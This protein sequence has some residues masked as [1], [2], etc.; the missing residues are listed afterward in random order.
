MAVN[1]VTLTTIPSKSGE[2]KTEIV[3]GVSQISKYLKGDNW[4]EKSEGEWVKF[5]PSRP[6]KHYLT[7]HFANGS[8]M[9]INLY[10]SNKEDTAYA[11]IFSGKGE[12]V[13]YSSLSNEDYTRVILSDELRD[14][15]LHNILK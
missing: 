11:S 10:F 2:E 5:Y 4:I 12:V 3:D 13:H 14:F 6:S 1:K 15:I 8:Y 9:H 7:V